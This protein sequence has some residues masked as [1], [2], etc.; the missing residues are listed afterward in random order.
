MPRN[1]EKCAEFWN[2]VLIGDELKKNTPQF[3]LHHILNGGVT[4]IKTRA[5]SGHNFN[6]I[7]YKV[8]VSWFNSW[9]TKDNRQS[10]KLAA[11]ERMPVVL[12]MN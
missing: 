7:V 10:V 2:R 5:Y 12:K 9:V 1:G 8:C 3:N 11:M 4:K 6:D